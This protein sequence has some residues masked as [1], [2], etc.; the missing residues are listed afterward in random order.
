MRRRRGGAGAFGS[1]V[2]TQS[3]QGVVVA[4]EDCRTILWAMKRAS[5]RSGHEIEAA[6]SM[7]LAKNE[8]LKEE[9]KSLDDYRAALRK[10]SKITEGMRK[11]LEQ[12]QKAT[13]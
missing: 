3:L 6:N 10:R 8:E 4:D 11:N 9:I 13:T 2:E 7:P 12:P 1:D 5:E